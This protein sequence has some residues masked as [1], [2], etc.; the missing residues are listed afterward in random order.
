MVSMCG[1]SAT[2]EIWVQLVNGSTEAS[3]TRVLSCFFSHLHPK[4]LHLNA[5]IMRR[6]PSVVLKTLAGAAF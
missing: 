2:L 5:F 6:V 1:D 4:A 3:D